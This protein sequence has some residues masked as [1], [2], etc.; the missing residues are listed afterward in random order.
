[1]E[2]P[3]LLN[4]NTPTI[5]N[6]RTVIWLQQTVHSPS[7]DWSKWD[8]IVTSIEEYHYWSQ[9]KTKIVGIVIIDKPSTA[10]ACDELYTVSKTVPMLLLSNNV[11]STKSEDYW[12]ENFDN[13]MC[14]N[15]MYD[16]YPFLSTAWDGSLADAVLLYAI[17]TRYGRV[18]DVTNGT[19]DLSSY[20]LTVETGIVPQEVWLI[21]QFFKHPSKK[22][23]A[24]IR[25]CLTRNA[26][27]EYVDKIVL[28]NEREYDLKGL[29]I[30]SEKIT[31]NM[32][33]KRLTYTDFLQYVCENVPLN[34]Y[35]ILANADIYMSDSLKEL[36]KINM[37]DRMFS[38]LRWDVKVD[39]KEEKE[40]V[41]EL[42]GP[43][44]DSQ[45]TWIL[46][47]DSVKSRSW[48]YATFRFE[49][50]QAGCDNSFAGYMLR[51][52]F[53]LLNPAL[54]FKTYHL[55]ITNI[56][57]Y[58]PK[59]PIRAKLYVNIVPTYIIDTKQEQVPVLPPPHHISN[60]LVSFEVKS[61]SMSN[62]ITYCTMLEKEGR[63]KWEPSVENHYFDAAI[64]IYSWNSACITSNGLV[65]DLYHIYT[66]KHVEDPNYKYW[67]HANVDIYTPLQKQEQMIAI[68]FSNCSVFQNPDRYVLEYI[69]RASRLLRIY[70]QASYM[71]PLAFHKYLTDLKWT[72]GSGNRVPFYE[73]SACWAEEVVGF[74]PGPM[75]LGQEDVAE[76]RDRLANY[77]MVTTVNKDGK[78]T[79]CIVY[80]PVIFVSEF[81]TAL[82]TKLFSEYELHTVS[83]NDFC[84]YDA[85]IG[86]SICI[87]LGGKNTE[88]R[89]AKLW[90]LPADCKVIEFQQELQLDGEFQHLA[91]VCG[92]TPYLLMLSKGTVEDVQEQVIIG[93]EKCQRK[94]FTNM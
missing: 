41:V 56:R 18:V 77:S 69:S 64:P 63:F 80:D 33:G 75:E 46:L 47:S 1:M 29:G 30:S 38:L 17:L 45:D 39:A 78:K 61:T 52:K 55:H 13:I 21:T 40:R 44:A 70:P 7:V 8:S 3:S 43:R 81:V 57:N 36:W 68:P 20:N 23:F 26:A 34:V 28:L 74:L 42:F 65:Y 51:S 79:L 60:S 19:R 93:L 83:E 76:L 15:Q 32:I 49:L 6:Q 94:Y 90:A 67:L 58:D 31:Q 22:R 91:H 12:V 85:V 11:L 9:H 84:V 50:G 71:Y 4:L 82:H 54:D 89:W 14:L 86:A 10:E 2:K 5:R 92:Y 72:L 24:E 16:H 48:N 35:V 25:E 59:D 37:H 88:T 53:V 66:G 62:E 87:F 73:D 27:C